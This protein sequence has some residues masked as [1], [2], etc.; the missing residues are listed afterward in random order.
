MSPFALLAAAAAAAL[1]ATNLGMRSINYICKVAGQ[2]IGETVLQNTN[3][4]CAQEP[5]GGEGVHNYA[6]C[7]TMRRLSNCFY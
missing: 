5:N 6:E 2:A 1:E 7:Y 4:V 3:P